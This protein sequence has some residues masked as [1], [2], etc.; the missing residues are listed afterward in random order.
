M[1]SFCRQHRSVITSWTLLQCSAAYGAIE[2]DEVVCLS[3]V[4]AI[5]PS[6][7][8]DANRAAERF[9]REHCFQILSLPL[10]R[11]RERTPCSSVATPAES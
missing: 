6:G 4:V 11:R 5:D 8:A 1:I 3:S 2:G 9:E 10:A 7:V